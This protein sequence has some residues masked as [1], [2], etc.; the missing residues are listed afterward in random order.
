MQR[1]ITPGVPAVGDLWSLNVASGCSGTTDLRTGR[2]R[3]IGTNVIIVADT[4]NP[5][6]GFTTAQYDSIALEIDSIAYPVVTGNFGSP[7]DTD[8]NSRVVAFFTRA[9]NELSPPA[10]SVTTYA[11]FQVRD[12]YSSDPASCSRSNEGEIIYMLVP[13]PTGSVNSNVRQVSLV[14]GNVV[15]R[16][17]HELQHLVNASKR[18][19]ELSAPLEEAWLDEGLSQI[20]EELMFYRTSVGV[21]PGQNI[22]LSTLT[23]GPNASRRVAAFNTYANDN[24]TALRGW[25]QRPD[26]TGALKTTNPSSL[27]FRGAAWAFLRY[28]ADRFAP[29]GSQ[30]AFWSS[31]IRTATGRTNLQEVLGVDPT[32]WLR[33]FT[34]ATYADDAVSGIATQYTQPSWNFRSVYGGLGGFPLGT[35][36]LSNGVALTLSYSLGGGTAYQRFGVAANS[37]ARVVATSGGVP[38]TGP[39]HLIVMRTK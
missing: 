15:K 20:S 6:G 38:P 32:L 4:A 1:I 12:L 21:T 29:G 22:T 37:F 3:S 28:S 27:S 13:D 24:F 33:D 10:S 2:V 19:Y 34:A 31:F 26:T 8:T 39:V 9:M 5:A 23:T 14:R 25:L 11:Q 36:P 35:R 17:G 16:F 30:Q 7:T 18:L